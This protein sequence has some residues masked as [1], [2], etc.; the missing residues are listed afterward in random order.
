MKYTT[1][2][3]SLLALSFPSLCTPQRILPPNWSFTLSS[4]FGPGCPDTGKTNPLIRTTR[5]THGTN[6]VDGSEIYYW[7][8]AYPWLRVD[9]AAGPR[10][11]WCEATVAYKEYA[12]TTG[13]VEADKYRLRLH[14]NGT[15]G[16]LT[17]KLDEGVR[18]YWDFAYYEGEGAGRKEVADTIDLTGPMQSGPHAQEHYSNISYPPQLIPQQK[19]GS[20]LFTF[21]TELWV[22]G[23]MGQTGVVESEYEDSVELG[24]QYYGT[25]QGFSYDWEKCD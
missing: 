25:Q 21:R 18:V 6:T 10:H 15:K 12:G 9:L 8:I 4:F 3:L 1:A 7:F 11:T 13:R 24:R 20:G 5:P 22:M 17:Y 19:C 2:A 14:K 16:L 23:E